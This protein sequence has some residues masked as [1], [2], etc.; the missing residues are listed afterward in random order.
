MN[1]NNGIEMH[2]QV[3]RKFCDKLCRCGGRRVNWLSG[4]GNGAEPDAKE[5]FL[6]RSPK[7][8]L[9]DLDSSSYSTHDCVSG[10]ANGWVDLFSLGDSTPAAFSFMSQI[11]LCYSIRLHGNCRNR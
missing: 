6:I 2:R 8:G 10:A 4:G 1:W 11:A 9:A 7:A 5:S 3:T